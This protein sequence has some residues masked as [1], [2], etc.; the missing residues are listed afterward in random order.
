MHNALGRWTSFELG[1][2]GQVLVCP[3]GSFEQH[4]PHLPLDTDTRIAQAIAERALS[5]FSTDDVVLGPTFSVGASGEHQDFVGTLSIGSEALATLLVEFVR[6]ADAFRGVIFINGHGGNFDAINK[7]RQIL[8]NEKRNVIFWSPAI[9]DAD[10]HAGEFETSL[11]L[12]IAP[13]VVRTDRFEVGVTELS[14]DDKLALRQ[15]GVAAVSPNGILGDPRGASAQKGEQLL[16]VIES[17]LRQVIT[18]FLVAS[19]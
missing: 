8:A 3:L 1:S 18:E 15:K 6:S 2:A 4:G 10:L 14:E 19:S 12:A 5:A 7:A 13:D 11:L 16:T 17:Q 9:T